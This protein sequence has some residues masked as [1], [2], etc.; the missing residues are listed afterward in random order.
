MSS[1]VVSDGIDALD[2][3]LSLLQ[4]P[5]NLLAAVVQDYADADGLRE[6]VLETTGAPPADCFDDDS[7]FLSRIGLTKSAG[8]QKEQRYE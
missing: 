5:I 1:Q 6:V 2:D 3:I 7:R 8:N 4:I